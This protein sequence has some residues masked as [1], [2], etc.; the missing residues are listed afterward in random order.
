MFENGRAFAIKQRSRCLIP[1]EGGEGACEKS[2][3]RKVSLRVEPLSSGQLKSPQQIAG[4]EVEEINSKKV[5]RLER[6]DEYL[7]GGGRY[8]THSK[9]DKL[10]IIIL[11]FKNSNSSV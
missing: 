5:E 8:I 3:E 10:Q 9:I 6:K 11:T 1:R 2:N 7:G 4:V